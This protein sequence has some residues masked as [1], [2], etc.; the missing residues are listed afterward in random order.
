MTMFD[1]DKIGSHLPCYLGC[2]DV[3]FNKAGDFTIGPNQFVTGDVELP[4]KD[5]MAIGNAR[6]VTELIVGFTEPSR[7]RELKTQYRILL[8]SV[9]FAMSGE[10]SFPKLRQV[11]FVFFVDN[12]LVGIGASIRPNGHGF[13]SKNQFCAT[14]A[15]AAPPPDDLLGNA[16]GRCP[17][18]PLHWLNGKTIADALAVYSH[19]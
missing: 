14:L 2:V 1:I 10:E 18:P 3:V 13:P 12:E 11:G 16:A 9:A 7:M 15:K 19:S 8:I 5:R 4:V 17:V 6:L